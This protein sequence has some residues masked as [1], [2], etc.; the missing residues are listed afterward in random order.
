M[1]IFMTNDDGFESPGLIEMAKKLSRLG[2]V[3]VIAPNRGRSSC[4]SSLSLQTYL[5]MRDL[6]LL[7]RKGKLWRKYFRPFLQRHHGRLLQAGPG[8]LAPE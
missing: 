5:R 4:S 3:T 6:S 1:H 7:S 8:T 2:R